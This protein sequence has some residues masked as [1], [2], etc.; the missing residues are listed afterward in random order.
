MQAA[1][2][3]VL[4]AGPPEARGNTD[5]TDAYARARR[6]VFETCPRVELPLAP[7]Q[8]LVLHRHLLHGIAPWPADADADAPADGRAVAWFR[9][10]LADVTAWLG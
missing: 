9:P 2:A 1:L 7:G 5:V 6:T 8:A 3:P 4:A 10:Q